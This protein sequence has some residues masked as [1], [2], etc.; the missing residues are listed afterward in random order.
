[1]ESFTVA[2]TGALTEVS[3]LFLGT[4]SSFPADI[5][6]SADGRYLY[7]A[8]WGPPSFLDVLTVGR[9]CHLHLASSLE[10][11]QARYY[12]ITL[13]GTTGLL[14]VDNANSKLDLYRITN[15]TQLTLVSSTPSQ[16]TGP[17]GA[18][19]ATIGGQ[20]YVFNGLA[21]VNGPGEVEAHTVNRQGMLGYVPG[22]PAEDLHSSA[23]PYVLFDQSH[24]QVI[25]SEEGGETLGVY[26]EC[27]GAL[28]FLSQA[29][30]PQGFGPTVMTELGATLYMVAN[31]ADAVYSCTIG[32]GAL[33]CALAATLP[34]H[35]LPEGIN[36]L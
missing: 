22:S 15:G 6:A 12:S 18:A 31:G 1:V 24:Q 25:E 23:G 32:V 13:L 19:T 9:G 16:L 33:T 2:A 20:E 27:G 7:V 8:V 10:Q 36:V 21:T 26:G 3:L 34:S 35:S 17:D 5:H 30:L 11:A 4:G 29:V 14:A 28:T